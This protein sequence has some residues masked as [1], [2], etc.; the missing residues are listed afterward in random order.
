MTLNNSHKALAITFLIIGTLVLSLL[1]L[2]VFKTNPALAETIYDIEQVEI[3]T[4][5]DIQELI[6][7]SD[8]KSTNKAFNTSEKYKHFAEAYKPIAPPEDYDNPMLQTYKNSLKSDVPTEKSDVKSAISEK[9]LTSFKG[10]NEVLNKRSQNKNTK[11]GNTANTNSSVYYS[12]KGRTDKSLPIPIYL[13]DAQGKIII[14]ITVDN[15]GQVVDAYVNNAS[16][17]NNLCLQEHAL[18]YAK[19]AT[20]DNSDKSKQLGSITFEFKGK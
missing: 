1:N 16:T 5:E 12:L 2:T 14:N 18:E 10:V 3:E 4:P 11:Q 6:Q 17:S 19:K 8:S 20:F 7:N 13:C 15:Q 9:T